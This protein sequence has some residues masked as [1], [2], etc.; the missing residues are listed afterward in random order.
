MARSL[1][2][3]IT[4]QNAEGSHAAG[5]KRGKTRASDWMK[6]GAIFLKPINKG[7]NANVKQIAQL[8]AFFH[9]IPQLN[10]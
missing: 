10:I 3:N 9:S 8:L 6:K 2:E 7:D 1:R 5:A 4:N